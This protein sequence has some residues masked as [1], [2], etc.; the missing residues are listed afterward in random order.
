[1]IAGTISVR[2]HMQRLRSAG[3]IVLLLCVANGAR[4]TDIDPLRPPDT[5]SP[6]ATLQGFIETTDDTYSRMAGVLEAYGKLRPAVSRAPTNVGNRSEALEDAPRALPI[7]RHV[8][9]PTR[10]EGHRRGRASV[11]AQGSPR[12]HRHPCFADIPDRGR[13]WRGCRRN[14]GGCRTPRSTSFWSKGR[15]AGEYLVS[16]ATIDRLPE[17]Y[18]R[19]KDLPYKPGPGTATGRRLSLDQSW[20]CAPRSMMRS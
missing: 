14:D 3:L 1:M 4:G 7:P 11:A 10:A 20:R 16:A 19:V 5:S 2:R 6:R 12:S 18:E 9:Y 13:R 17:F 8:R 15:R